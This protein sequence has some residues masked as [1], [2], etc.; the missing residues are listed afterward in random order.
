[1]G[2]LGPEGRRRLELRDL[3]NDKLFLLYEADLKIRIRNER[4]IKSVLQFLT[5]FK[6]YLGTLPP[7]AELAKG[8][9]AL[10]TGLKPHTWYNYTGEIKR[11]MAWYG[12]PTNIKAKLP[13]SLPDYHDDA[14]IEVLLATAKAK[15]THKKAIPRDLLLIEVAWRTGL[16]RAELSN[17]TAGDVHSNFLCVRSGKGKKD[18]LLPLPPGISEKLHNF[19][20]NMDPN[21]KIFKL[22]PTS[23]GMKIKDLARRAGLVNFHTHS[24][25][26]KY[27]TDLL[28]KGA[29][30][31]V[32]Q[33]LLG[34]E[35]LATTEVY[36]ALTDKSL[37]DA[38][39][40]LEP[41]PEKIPTTLEGWDFVQT[42]FGKL[43]AIPPE[44]T[45]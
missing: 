18:R 38:V 22:N 27:A 11:F 8:F 3:S 19:T 28:E 37:H 35:N 31:K 21:E 25:R 9:L 2:L 45:D 36:L 17:L 41:K 23:L 20:K 29:N 15:R 30:L 14:E 43:I 40:L 32:V 34:H 10:Y 5:R 13:K 39:K 6:N 44:N 4:N 42:L 26:H 7:S 12:E 24:L 16:R 1:M 33:K